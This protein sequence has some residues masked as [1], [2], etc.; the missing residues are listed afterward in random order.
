MARCHDRC[1]AIGFHA[2]GQCLEHAPRLLCNTWSPRFDRTTLHTTAVVHRYRLGRLRPHVVS[3]AW[4]CD[5]RRAMV[6]GWIF[7]SE[8]IR[9]VDLVDRTGVI[10]MVAVQERI[11]V[12]ICIYKFL[13]SPGER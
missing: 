6:F 11:V 5:L 13:S 2:I 9:Q 8:T 12:T 1:F 10:R 7:F 4:Q 3:S